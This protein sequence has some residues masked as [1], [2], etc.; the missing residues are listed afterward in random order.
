MWEAGL[1]DNLGARFG[2]IGG[3]LM[4]GRCV[5]EVPLTSSRKEAMTAPQDMKITYTSSTADMTEFHRFFDDALVAI[6]A[7]SGQTHPLFI[8]GEPVYSEDAVIEDVSPI[9]TQRVLGYFQSAEPEHVD[10]AVESARSAARGWRSMP[11]QRRVEILREAANGIRRRKFELGA[12]MSL[13]VGKNRMESMGDAEESADL[14]D[15]YCQ[16]MVDANGFVQTMN[17]ITPVETN[18]DVLRPYGVFACVAPFNFPAALG[19][20]MS[21]AA[22]VAGNTVVFKPATDTP[23]TGLKLYEIYTEAG[24]PAGVFNYVTGRGSK[25][26]DRL[27]LHEGIDGVVFTGSKAVGMRIYHGLS[28]NWIRPCL[29]EL[30]GKNPTIVMDSADLDAAAEGVWRSAWGL[31]NQKCSACSR[32]YVHRDV[33]EAFTARLIART[34]KVAIGDP[35][36]PEVFFGPLINAKAVATW[37][38]AVARAREEGEVLIGG[39]RLTEGPLARGHYVA[40]TIAKVPLHS[41]LFM[42]EFF[43]PFLAIGVVDSLEQAIEES[44]R[45]EYGLTA[46]VFSQ[47]QDELDIFFDEI[48]SGVAYANKRSGATTGA[49]PGAQPF[50]GWKG[51]GGSGKGGCGPYYVAQFMREQCRT[52]IVEK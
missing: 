34:E 30:G 14:I 3:S 18:T 27:A 23:W 8:G 46:G 7:A 4:N 33:A 40:P 38:R 10:M 28:Q 44:N 26:G 25:I 41:S 51:S 39:E 36:Q 5:A 42:D 1:A 48:H 9:D 17:S 47:K 24:V 37:E 21:S 15:Y 49:W 45:S 16:Q 2:R 43:A 32:V 35:T 12:L 22:L 50:T 52:V 13:E 31:Q 6:E 19:F 11:W 20:G 29:V